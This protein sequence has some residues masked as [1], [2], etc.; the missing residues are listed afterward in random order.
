[1]IIASNDETEKYF[2][3]RSLYQCLVLSLHWLEFQLY[4]VLL[5]VIF[6]PNTSEHVGVCVQM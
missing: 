2:L 4:F 3:D 5:V 6:N 1:M